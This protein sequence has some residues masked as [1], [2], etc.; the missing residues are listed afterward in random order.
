MRTALQ[1]GVAVAHAERETAPAAAATS[2]ASCAKTASVPRS[3]GA[4]ARS[5]PKVSSRERTAASHGQVVTSSPRYDATSAERSLELV[6]GA[7]EH[8]LCPPPSRTR[9][10]TAGTPSRCSARRAGSACVP[11]SRAS[12][13]KSVLVTIGARPSDG[14]SS[15]SMPR[16][17][18]ERA[19]ERD[20]LLL[21]ARERPAV[22]VAERPRASGTAG[23]RRRCRSRCRG[24]RRAV[25][26]TCRFSCT[27]SVG[28]TRRPSGTWISPR[29]AAPCTPELAAL[30]AVE[31][32][33]AAIGDE[34]GDRVQRRRLA[35]A[36]GADH[37]DDLAVA[38]VEVDAEDGF[39]RAVRDLDVA[40]LEHGQSSS[41]T[42]R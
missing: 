28:N 37:R 31:R 14:S 38:D 23:T 17:G 24:P 8:D 39:D 34:A 4:T 19:T 32:D 2:V 25:S 7:G 13:A 18:D 30:D 16:A 27:V 5:A 26:P 3:R 22:A 40:Q 41:S 33:R 12:A 6:G 11:R 1:T 36:V 29:R 21:A 10:S 9:A 20:H 42:P 15:S 35:R